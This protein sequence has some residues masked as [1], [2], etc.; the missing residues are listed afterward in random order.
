MELLLKRIG[1]I[2]NVLPRDVMNDSK[3][4]CGSFILTEDYHAV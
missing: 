3:G 2:Q 4:L 1:S